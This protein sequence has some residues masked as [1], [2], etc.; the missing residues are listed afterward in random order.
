MSLEK[1]NKDL[2]L[3]KIVGQM[4]WHGETY[5][6]EQSSENMEKAFE[7]ACSLIENIYDNATLAPNAVAT[8]SGERLHK[9]AKDMLKSIKETCEEV[10]S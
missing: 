8:Y 3:D 9:R 1:A 6:D 7:L 4:H 2:I 5:A 10:E